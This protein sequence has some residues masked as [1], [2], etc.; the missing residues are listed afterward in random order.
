[1]RPQDTR[2]RSLRARWRRLGSEA[3]RR[4]LISAALTAGAIALAVLTSGD[5]RTV[6]IVLALVVSLPLTIPLVFGLLISMDPEPWGENEATRPLRPATARRLGLASVSLMAAAAVA[7]YSVNPGVAAYQ[8]GWLL[9]LP[10]VVTALLWLHR[11]LPRRVEWALAVCVAPIGPA[12]YLIVGGDRL[13]G[14]VVMTEL[15][16]LLLMSSRAGSPDPLRA[17]V[18]SIAG[19]LEGP[20]GPP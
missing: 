6:V 19:P 18:R 16:L 14:L 15:P 12:A 11:R 3:R 8:V 2:R 4:T 17:K 5:V 9:V 20:W 10:F 1:M 13:W 7:W